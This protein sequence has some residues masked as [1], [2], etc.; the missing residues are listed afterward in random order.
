MFQ[1]A[2]FLF[3]LYIPLQIALSPASDIDLASLRLFSLL[4]FLI[5][6]TH[7]LLIKKVFIPLDLSSLFLY[8]TLFF[9]LFSLFLAQMPFWGIRKILFIYSLF[10]IYLVFSSFVRQKG[11][12]FI[13]KGLVL[14][15]FVVSIIGIG[16][17]IAQFIF[18]LDR[19]YAFW[20]RNIAPLFLGNA[21]SQAVLEHPSWLV[22]ISGNTVFRAISVFPDPHMFSFY[23]GMTLPLAVFLYMGSTRSRSLYLLSALSLLL[24]DLLT[25]SRGG[26]LGLLAGAAVAAIIYL[27]NKPADQRRF[28]RLALGTL[29][30]LLLLYLVPPIK[31]RFLASFDL[32]DGSNQGRIALWKKSLDTVIENPLGIGI[33]NLPL[34]FEPT[35]SYRDPIYAH[36]LYLDVASEMGTPALIGLLLTLAS[37]SYLFWKN[38]KTNSLHLGYLSSIAIFSTHS[39]VETPLYSVH[40][41]ALF[42]I[43]LSFSHETI[44]KQID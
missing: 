42:F 28:S 21:F 16:Q 43:L 27:R 6:L 25:F 22:N 24:A 39:L 36:N 44:D 3:S 31:D 12:L 10:P 41:L 23:M 19:T 11:T 40:V 37:V 38:S 26:Y 33:G 17:F 5:W 13:A 2:L 30:L 18:G 29:S 7:S 8:S 15:S 34:V 9:A 35:A 20:G 4:L 1:K 14:G 32:N